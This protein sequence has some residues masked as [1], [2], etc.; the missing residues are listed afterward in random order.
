MKINSRMKT[1]RAFHI[2]EI[3][4]AQINPLTRV[5][6]GTKGFCLHVRKPEQ[7]ADVIAVPS[8]RIYVFTDVYLCIPLLEKRILMIIREMKH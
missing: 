1:D 7:T 4:A 3:S 6:A 2:D 5:D 8:R